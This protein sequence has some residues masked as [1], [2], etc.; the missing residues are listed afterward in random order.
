MAKKIRKC[1]MCGTEYEYCSH[2]RDYNPNETWRYLYHDENCKAVGELWFAYKGKEISK[3]DTKK[4]LQSY[5]LDGILAYDSI[6]VK[7]LKDILGIKEE[8]VEE[9]KEEVKAEKPVNEEPKEV[10]VEKEE[11]P[12]FDHYR[13]KKK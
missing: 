5:K 12:A 9:P 13:N 6:A 10:K 3:E 7:E 11:K 4:A 2:C 1:A 8:K